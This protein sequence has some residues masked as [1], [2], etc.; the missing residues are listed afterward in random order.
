[1]GPG[2]GGNIDGI[3]E[4]RRRP[5][6]G[7]WSPSCLNYSLVNNLDLTFFLSA[8]YMLFAFEETLLKGA[9]E[10]IELEDFFNM[11]FLS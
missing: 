1:M 11:G 10:R 9:A 3:M 2:P 6:S 8:E 7:Y 5:I 4:K